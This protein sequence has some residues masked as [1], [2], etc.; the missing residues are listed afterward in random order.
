MKK[1]LLVTVSLLFSMGL[2]SQNIC[3]IKGKVIN[4]P[5]SKIIF[6]AP[7]NLDF[8]VNEPTIINISEDGTFDCSIEFEDSEL[9]SLTFKEEY[10]RGYVET[11]SLYVRK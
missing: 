6:V 4:R 3:N 1:L 7:M 10:S 8:R 9:Y 11:Y 5:K 2:M